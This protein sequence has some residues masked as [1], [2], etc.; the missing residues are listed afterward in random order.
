MESTKTVTSRSGSDTLSVTTDPNTHYAR[1]HLHHVD[2]FDDTDDLHVTLGEFRSSEIISALLPP[3]PAARHVA[4][5]TPLPVRRS[6][7]R[8]KR[9]SR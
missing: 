6:S 8:R 7:W 5:E 1:L 3:V 2:G 9:D 4:A